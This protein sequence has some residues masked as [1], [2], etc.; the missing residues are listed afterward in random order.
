MHLF[1]QRA[2]EITRGKWAVNDKLLALAKMPA[3]VPSWRL[4]LCVAAFFSCLVA[5]LLLSVESVPH[6][7]LL[8]L[9]FLCTFGA[10]KLSQDLRSAHVEQDLAARMELVFHPEAPKAAF[11]PE[12]TE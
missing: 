3:W 8:P 4:S 11:W 2:K 12:I 5:A 9:V 10:S 6:R 7:F 1:A